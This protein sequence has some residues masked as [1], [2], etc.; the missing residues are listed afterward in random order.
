MEI[1]QQWSLDLTEASDKDSE[2]QHVKSALKNC[3]YPDWIQ[4]QVRNNRHA[5]ENRSETQIRSKSKHPP[6]VIP[7]MKGLSYAL[8]RTYDKFGIHTYFKPQN[9]LRRIIGSP[10][11]KLDPL[12]TCGPI[13]LIKCE[14]DG[15]T[16]CHH[17]YVG[18]TERSLRA[19]VAEHLR[20]SSV[21]SEVS[22]TS[23]RTSHPVRSM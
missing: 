15:S 13:Y 23:I 10:K 12:D 21:S 9:T 1:A 2:F 19:R 20:P 22:S 16:K 14:G 17:S 7:F 6:V 5:L 18:E 8:R 3:G 4:K 11:D